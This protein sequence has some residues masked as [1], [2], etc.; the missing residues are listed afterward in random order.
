MSEPAP[1]I[2]LRHRMEHRFDRPVRLST[3]WLRLCPAPN[4]RANVT[5]YTLRVG[6]RTHFLNWLRDPFENHLARLDLPEATRHFTLDVEILAELQPVNPFDFLAEPY[7]ASHPFDYPGQLARDLAPYLQQPVTG[8]ATRAWLAE[9]DATEVPTLQRLTTLNQRVGET[10]TT[11]RGDA[12]GNVDTDAVLGA[13]TGSPRALAWLLTLALRH[14]G[15]AARLVSGYRVTGAA[16][17]YHAALAAWVEAYLPG[18]GWIGLDPEAGLFTAEQHI[19]LATGADPLRLRPVIGYREACEETIS[20]H[21]E[22]TTLTAAEPD[23]PYTDAQWAAIRE[24]ATDVDEHLQHRGI[25]LSSGTALEFTR[26]DHQAAPEWRT[27][28]PGADKLATAG[29]LARRLRDR[30]LPGAVICTGQGEWFAGEPAPRWRMY[31]I[32]R[33]DGTPMWQEP[34]LL[35]APGRDDCPGQEA[36]LTLATGIARQLGL[37]REDLLPAH[38]DQLFTLWSDRQAMDFRPDGSDLAT[39]EARLALARHLDRAHGTP[40]GF[41]LPLHRE[42]GT[43]TWR[44]GPWPTRRGTVTLLPGEAP[45]GFRLPLGGLPRTADDRVEPPPTRSPWDSNEPLP[46][47]SGADTSCAPA[48]SPIMPTTALCVERRQGQLHV[49]LPPLASSDDFIHLVT[50]VE[51][52][53]TEFGFPVHLEGYTSPA[54]A[55]LQCV[56]LEPETGTLR[57]TVPP[58]TDWHQECTW[59][60]AVYDEA[61]RLG[62]SAWT[63]DADLPTPAGQ[64]AGRHL[65]GPTP[66]DS[67]FLRDPGLLRSLLLYWQRHPS[68]S[69]LFAGPRVG[70]DGWAPRLDEISDSHMRELALAL[71]RLPHGDCDRPWLADRVLSHLITDPT[72]DPRGGEFRLHRLY[73]AGAG[74]DRLGIVAMH[75]FAMAPHAGLAGVQSLLLRAIVLRLAERPE[76]G[77]PVPWGTTLHDRFLLPEILQQDFDAVLAELGECGARLDGRWL[78]P[79]ITWMFPRLADLHAGPVRLRLQPAL[80]PWPVLAEESTGR[81]SFRFIDPA[82]ARFQVHLTGLTPNRHV[83]LCNGHHVPLQDTG[84]GGEAVAGIRCKVADPPATLYP[85]IPPVGALVFDLVDTWTGRTVGG[86]T[87]VLP[88]TD[89]GTDDARRAPPVSLAPGTTAPGPPASPAEPRPA[90][91]SPAPV[92]SSRGRLLPEGSPRTPPLPPVR[93]TPPEAPY[94]LD[95]ADPRPGNGA[96]MA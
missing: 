83:L 78:A 45:M 92:V 77:T 22:V 95:L 44:S 41:I 25:T 28:G 5:A 80:E 48:T 32:A 35:D 8:P 29:R 82:N 40:T 76:T 57:I 19:P 84:R 23:G 74:A 63:G 56:E 89:T 85:G 1:R 12:P 65:G 88:D 26:P 58:V 37:A 51:A 6:P 53:A 38:E 18:A 50:A 90:P 47:R 21:L 79:W 70:P 15:M 73:P 30:L 43:G 61:E 42:P 14:C 81:G 24:T 93:S 55:R 62:L 49:F 39:P 67:P 72:G 71:E 94:L 17:D 20:E 69:Y 27:T 60:Q 68:L 36:V 10:L 34:G 87:Y 64:R 31:C 33:R 9:L 52:T 4:T 59:L 54:D 7:A 86:C 13:G 11:T 96:G 66:A 16:P 2:V 75:A 91:P 3:H 46:P